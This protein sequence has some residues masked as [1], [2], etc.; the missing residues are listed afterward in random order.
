MARASKLLTK[1]VIEFAEL[2]LKDLGKSGAVAVKLR[3]IIAADE[4]GI[5]QVAKIFGTT[6]ATLIS[7]IKVVRE[8]SLELL[9]VQTGRGRKHPIT[10]E[11]DGVIRKWIEEDSQ[12][13][14][15]KLRQ[16]IISELGLNI[17]RSSVHRIMKELKFSYITARPRHYKQDVASFSEAKKKSN[18]DNKSVT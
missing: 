1:E 4:Y 17:S 2:H 16:K 6:K 10:S 11:H 9:T 7:W 8:G 5:T 12:I 18:T 3:A 15:D 14:I 13:T